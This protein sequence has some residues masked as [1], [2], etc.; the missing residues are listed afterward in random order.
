MINRLYVILF[1]S[2]SPSDTANEVLSTD[3]F[4]SNI[5]ATCAESLYEVSRLKHATYTSRDGN[6]Y[7]GHVDLTKKCKNL[8]LHGKLFRINCFRLFYEGLSIAEFIQVKINR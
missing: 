7:G 3:G 6:S 8:I 2:V 1:A 5:P 4:I